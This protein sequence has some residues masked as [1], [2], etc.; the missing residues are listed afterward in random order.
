MDMPQ[1]FSPGMLSFPD[2]DFDYSAFLQA[3]DITFGESAQSQLPSTSDSSD[4]AT[5]PSGSSSEVAVQ[6]PSAQKQRLERRGHT[7]SRRGCYNC[8]RRRIKCQETHPACG[9]CTKTG[10]KC[11]YP[12]TP[13]I[14]HQPHHQV[15]LFSLQDMRFFQHFLTQCYPHHPLK[16]EDI[17]THEIPCI[18]HNNEYLMHAILGFSASELMRDDPSILS[19]AMNH[20]I[21]AIR[22]IKKRLAETN[23]SSMNYEEANAMVATCFALTFQ[24]VSLDDGLAEYLTFIRGIMI[25]GMQMMFRGI[26]PIFENMFEQDQD[27][28]LEPLMQGLPLIP[29][30]FTDSAFE[31]LTNLKPLCTEEVELEYH[32]HLMAMVE[33]LYVNSWDAYKAY[34]T[35]YGW[36]ML[37]PHDTFQSLIDPDNQ[38]MLLLHTHWVA[39]N[40]IITPISGQERN[41]SN[42]Y[43][44][45]QR[46]GKPDLDPGFSRWLKYLNQS[47]DLEHQIYNQWP[48][49]VEEKLDNDV[50]FFGRV[51]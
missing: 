4:K 17:W 13:Q 22:A 23:K 50:T 29:K 33:K 21:K 12:S 49:W 10:L 18:A 47:I 42:K 48:M 37:L 36:W 16:Q 28:L 40:E 45:D 19:S 34:T 31:A 39:I 8:K 7:K 11:E 41:V 32:Q 20:R 24:S 1:G 5:P 3:D 38:V 30:G 27:A 6:R 2:Q 14:T 25:V 51:A 35:Q 15:P 46:E 9:H 26:K 44:P 43:P